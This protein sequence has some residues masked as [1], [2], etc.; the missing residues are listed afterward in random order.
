M[1]ATHWGTKMIHKITLQ[2]ERGLKKRTV[3]MKERC[4]L[5]KEKQEQQ[6]ENR[7]RNNKFEKKWSKESYNVVGEEEEK[8][9]LLRGRIE[10]CDRMGWAELEEEE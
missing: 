6:T 5:R 4:I 8:E 7:K 2:N 3:I 10:E 9:V 1:K